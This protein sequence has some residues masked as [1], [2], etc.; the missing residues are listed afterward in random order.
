MLIGWLVERVCHGLCDRLKLGYWWTPGNPRAF[1]F[2]HVF[3][4]LFFKNM[5]V[6]WSADVICTEIQDFSIV[7]PGTIQCKFNLKV[8]MTTYYVLKYCMA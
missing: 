5:S 6:T 7:G 3:T 2:I 4:V 8:L 1:R